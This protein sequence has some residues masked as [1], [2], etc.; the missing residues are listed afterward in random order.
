[1]LLRPVPPSNWY[2]WRETTRYCPKCKAL[3]YDYLPQVCGRDGTKL[4][5]FKDNPFSPPILQE[6]FK[7]AR[8]IERSEMF[9]EYEALD[10]DTD[11]PVRVKLLNRHLSQDQRTVS[12]LFKYARPALGLTHDRIITLISVNATDE[13]IPYLI[14]DLVET[15]TLSEEL[16]TRKFFTPSDAKKIFADFLSAIQCAHDHGI[17]HGGIS[18]HNLFLHCGTD[19]LRGYVANFGIA[20]R[21]FREMD[22]TGA[23]TN[24]HTAN[25]YGDPSTICPEFCVGTRPT[26]ASDIYQIGCCLYQCLSGEIPF[27]RDTMPMI[28]IAHMS[29]PPDDIRKKKSEI[30]PEL[31]EIV[32][33]CLSKEPAGRYPS[34][35]ALSQALASEVTE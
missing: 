23:S 35:L 15:R 1:M 12:N 8:F 11:K 24:T 14:T 33:R 4:E 5:P 31:A 28:L 17:V 30:S 27:E 29:D 9:E 34:A 3:Y 19:S 26:P 21:L 6:R 20:E 2:E 10:L 18:M 32:Y 22:W 16:G 7:L 13:G 25:V